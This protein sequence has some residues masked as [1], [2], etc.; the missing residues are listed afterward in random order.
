[1]PSSDRL[2][3]KTLKTINFRSISPILFCPESGWLLIIEQPFR[4]CCQVYVC[5][6]YWLNVLLISKF[7]FR[8]QF[9]RKRGNV[10]SIYN[11][12]SVIRI[13]R[14][15]STKNNDNR[16]SSSWSSF[17]ARWIISLLVEVH[18]VLGGQLKLQLDL[19][20]FLLSFSDT[21]F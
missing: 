3:A 15:C 18:S 10:L 19:F 6:F 20:N 17:I 5:A 7:R 1:M 21:A 14:Y 4:L 12:I 11:Y 16:S 8:Y 2:G 13:T 9:I